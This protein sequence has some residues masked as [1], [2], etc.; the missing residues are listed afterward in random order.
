MV[1]AVV[2]NHGVEHSRDTLSKSHYACAAYN[3][4]LLR[5]EEDMA[6]GGR[7]SSGAQGIFLPSKKPNRKSGRILVIIRKFRD[8]WSRMAAI[9]AGTARRKLLRGAATHPI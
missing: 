5:S 6:E 4:R 9:S 7:D 3:V 1:T 2:D 8:S